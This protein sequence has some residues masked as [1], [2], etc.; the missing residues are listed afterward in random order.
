MKHLTTF[1]IVL[2]L[3]FNQ[4]SG[5]NIEKLHNKAL[6]AYD[7]GDYFTAI[8][9]ID[10]CIAVNPSIAT[11]WYKRGL[12]VFKV[13]DFS[14]SIESLDKA[15][16]LNSAHKKAYYLRG[17]SYLDLKK[18]DKAITDFNKVISL[19]STYSDAYFMIGDVHEKKEDIATACKYYKRAI[20]Y[21]NNEAFSRMVYFRKN[22]LCE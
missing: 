18:Y 9:Y 2:L 5:Q 11:F 20:K 3:A 10:Q 6:K 19:D 1:A 16:D 14:S 12:F 8:D 17:T 7:K 15:I 13:G 22:D 21:G 4:T